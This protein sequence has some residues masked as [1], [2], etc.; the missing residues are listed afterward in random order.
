MPSSF[1]VFLKVKNIPGSSMVPGHE[2]WSDAISFGHAACVPISSNLQITAGSPKFQR[3]R[4]LK[5]VDK[6]SPVLREAVLA[7][8]TFPDILIE[9]VDGPNVFFEVH[10][11]QARVRE[12]TSSGTGPTGRSRELVSL[13]FENIEWSFDDGK[14]PTQAQYNNVIPAIQ[15]GPC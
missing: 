3:V 15:F 11:R 8:T 4:V 5:L 10:L 13:D 6:A 14:S 12:I 2:G 1:Q 7:G 9:L